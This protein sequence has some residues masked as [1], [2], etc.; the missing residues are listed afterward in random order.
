MVFRTSDWSFMIAI[1]LIPFWLHRG[2][3]PLIFNM[4]T[5]MVLLLK[6]KSDVSSHYNKFRGV[7]RPNGAGSFPEKEGIKMIPAC[8]SICMTFLEYIFLRF[9]RQKPI[10][11]W[12]SAFVGLN[13]SRQSRVGFLFHRNSSQTRLF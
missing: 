13:N 12:I 11:V 7:R 8:A 5:N 9:K 3:K 10:C 4:K 2:V 6:M 1:F